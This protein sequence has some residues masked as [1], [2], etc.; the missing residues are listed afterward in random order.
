MCISE[1]QRLGGE[2]PARVCKRVKLRK[3]ATLGV[4]RGQAIPAL[5]LRAES[6]NQLVAGKAPP[7][8]ASVK[9]QGAHFQTISYAQFR[10]KLSFRN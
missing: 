9:I 4:V 8:L 5:I 2:E 6:E 3:R 1:H 10:G 7:A